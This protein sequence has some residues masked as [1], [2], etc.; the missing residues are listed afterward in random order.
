MDRSLEQFL[1]LMEKALNSKLKEN[2]EKESNDL[3]F[4]ISWIVK[5]VVKKTMSRGLD[6]IKSPIVLIVIARILREEI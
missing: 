1:T 4:W 3:H 2:L 5:I 6:F